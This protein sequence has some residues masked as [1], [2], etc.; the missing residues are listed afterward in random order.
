MKI[1]FAP[2]VLFIFLASCAVF[3]AGP[4]LP[5][6]VEAGDQDLSP[7]YRWTAAM[8][9]RPGQMLREEE[10]PAQPEINAASSAVRIL[11]TSDDARWRSGLVPVSG[12]MYLPMGEVPTGGWPLVAW[13]HG[14][15]GVADSCA[16]SLAMH[17]AR[18]ATYINRWLKAG[19]AVVATDYQGLGGPGPHPYLIWQA[20][21][22]SVLDSVR[23]AL[24]ARPGKIA[25]MV[26]IT[27]QS[28]GS[29]AALGAARLAPQYAPEIRLVGT[30]ATGV[31]SSFPDGPY[32]PPSNAAAGGGAP[33]YVI[34]SMV[35]GNLREGAPRAEE[36]VSDLAKPVLDEARRA[37]APA[38]FGVA[39]RLKVDMVT[40]F[41]VSEKELMPLTLNAIEMTSVQMT[42]P[43]LLGTG[44]SDTTIPPRHQYAAVRA[45]CATGSPVVWKTY[46]GMT[47]NGGL[48]ASFDDALAF[49]RDRMAGKPLAS[50]CAN[51]IEPE[52]PGPA[53]SGIVFND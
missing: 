1:V 16:P 21:G 2:G 42:V 46:A 11:Y 36:L 49:M 10:Q 39:R 34:M 35:G 51:A 15:L 24:Q 3:A 12:T 48:N 9:S 25:N 5:T 40:A 26:L 53:T 52:A 44:L 38:V 13:A 41:K 18:D 45:L 28:Q 7:F 6:G 8:P 30:V 23:A 20:E 47:H 14:T 19:F 33:H 43:L 4:S 31:V 29:G 32:K 22:R 17:K 27:G 37:C 50:N